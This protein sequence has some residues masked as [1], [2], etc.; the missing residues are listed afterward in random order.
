MAAGS[1]GRADL[2]SARNLVAVVA[3]VVVMLGGYML[4]R[5]DPQSEPV[6]ATIPEPEPE[7]VEE[8]EEEA[9]P[10]V[11]VP[12]PPPEPT[13]PTVLVANQD[14][15]P[16]VTVTVDMVE[17]REWREP[18][19]VDLDYAVL[20]DVE[21]QPEVLGSVALQRIPKGSQITFDRLIRPGQPSFIT[22]VVRPG[23]QAMT[24]TVD[25]ATT[26]A[27]VIY[28]GDRGD[29]IIVLPAG[30][31]G[32]L[33][34][35]GAIAQVLVRDVRVLAVG[36]D[37]LELGFSARR[38]AKRLLNDEDPDLP[39]GSTFTLEVPV[40]D[41]ERLALGA[42]TG[43]LTFAMR[44]IQQDPH[45][46]AVDT[47]LTDFTKVL[48][49]PDRP[50]QPEQPEENRYSAPPPLP[51]QVRIIRGGSR[52]ASNEVVPRDPAAA[53]TDAPESSV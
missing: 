31:V 34:D 21:D 19:G 44:S 9:P 43:R 8:V 24:V 18:L 32:Q 51:P 52:A 42:A 27:R 47:R 35:V 53:A 38:L 23:H 28:P 5:P 26:N 12:E 2:L 36:S 40:A 7:P 49:F 11:E 50:E 16:G 25:D 41:V 14:I 22:A 20:K 39:E 37:S 17:W 46:E 33:H 6:V 48:G 29:V 4:L 45:P 15:L 1:L 13:Y 10:E 3:A 30:T